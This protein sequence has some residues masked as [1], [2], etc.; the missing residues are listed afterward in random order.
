[1]KM[2]MKTVA[3]TIAL[4]F[5]AQTHAANLLINGSFET[6]VVTPGTFTFPVGV[7]SNALTGWTGVIDEFSVSESFNAFGA[8]V[9]AQD[10]NQFLDLTGRNDGQNRWGGITQNVATIAGATYRLSFW[11]GNYDFQTTPTGVFAQ[12]G[13]ANGS[14][15]LAAPIGSPRFIWE[16]H[17][18][19]FLA[20]GASTAITLTGT[21]GFFYTGLDNVSVELLSGVVGVPEPASWALMIAGFGLVGAALRRRQ[22]TVSVT[23]A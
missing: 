16:N 5:T 18:L 8:Q 10:G 21:S 7:G 14:F 13:S 20:T 4:A 2:W 17:T 19:D 12:A 22:R 6:P 3:A 1:M 9:T 23:Y 11:L 15:S